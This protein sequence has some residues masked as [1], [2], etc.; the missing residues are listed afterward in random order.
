M[1][2]MK[3]RN[4]AAFPASEFPSSHKSVFTSVFMP[5]PASVFASLCVSA[6]VLAFA[7]RPTAAAPLFTNVT[8]THVPQD[9]DLHS[10]DAEFGDFD[11]DGDLD[12]AVAVEGDVNRLYLNDGKGRL[13]W[14][15]G[16]FSSKGADGED[17]AV[18][19]FNR[20][21][22]LDVIFV[23]EDGG[24]HQYYLGDGKGAFQD[25]SS[26]LPGCQAN[27]VE[28]AD[29][30][31][32]GYE[33]VF[34]GCAG[35]GSSGQDLLLVNDRK[36]GF[37]NETAQRLPPLT[38][39][40]Q[41]VKVAD[42]D[43]D[44]DLD[45]VCGN[46]SGRNRLLFNIGNGFYADSAQ[47]LPIPYPEETRE[48]LLFD[49]DGDKDR[50]LV[51]CNLTCNACG[52]FTRNPQVRLLINN[53]KGK[54]ADET[55]ARMPANTF[56]SWDGGYLDFDAD[57]DLDL[58]ICAITVPGFTGLPAKA[59]RNDSKGKFTDA[60]AEVM[61][62][63]AG[64]RLWDVEVA[65]LDKD[66]ALDVFMGAWGT[67]AILMLGAVKQPV[68][69]KRSGPGMGG[70]GVGGGSRLEGGAGPDG[71]LGRAR[72]RPTLL[73]TLYPDGKLVLAQAVRFPHGG[74]AFLSDGSRSGP[75]VK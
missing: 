24:V 39:S 6:M 56:S 31:G 26:R 19:D 65:D 29:V 3:K 37:I 41:D 73:P 34:I 46:E 18:A 20:D 61:P 66:G 35:G 25:V 58:I 16:V 11:K 12:V 10:L 68:S 21:G 75:A 50:D 15:P 1:D 57:G 40:T 72:G 54:F 52:T 69:I 7:A 28:A 13:A 9:A 48:V 33:D 63:G 43:G 2:R 44:G 38:E 59:Y 71:R 53:G 23:M 45:L 67:Q 22:N 60:T 51:F 5:V 49:A 62:A 55:A 64:G 8:S 14:K 32:D 47:N 74:A 30:T 70:P 36:G 17:L 42:L 4:S 27:A